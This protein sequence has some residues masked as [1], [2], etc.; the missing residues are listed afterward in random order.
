MWQAVACV[1]ME[2]ALDLA[3]PL[4]SVHDLGIVQRLQSHSNA[5]RLE[6]G[7]PREN[8]LKRQGV[9][10]SKQ[11]RGMF[12]TGNI[13]MSTEIS[14]SQG[15]PH[16]VESS[17]IRTATP[18]KKGTKVV[19]GDVDNTLAVNTTPLSKRS[20]RR[21]PRE[22][23][24]PEGIATGPAAT[25]ASTP[26][27]DSASSEDEGRRN[28]Y[29]KNDKGKFSARKAKL[30]RKK[31]GGA[32]MDALSPRALTPRTDNES[33]QR[34]KQADEIDEESSSKLEKEDHETG[35]RNVRPV[36]SETEM[37]C[38]GADSSTRHETGHGYEDQ[39]NA[40]SARRMSPN[41]SAKETPHK[42]W[43]REQPQQRLKKRKPKASDHARH[44][45]APTGGTRR[46]SSATSDTRSA[47]KETT[48]TSPSCSTP[49][50][51]SEVCY[52]TVPE[53]TRSRVQKVAAWVHTQTFSAPRVH[54]LT[55]RDA[56]VC[57]LQQNLQLT[58]HIMALSK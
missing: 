42:T 49:S 31:H 9:T 36:L 53:D 33:K 4:A 19:N 43:K 48:K 15:T 47:N 46:P 3:E 5:G 56:A 58:L 55:P 41:S 7:Q 1:V 22:R 25:L 21:T 45:N 30:L 18:R 17:P 20:V 24:T 29:L 38:K 8:D 51:A 27:K 40:E 34:D 39:N 23:R 28:A 12:Q 13:S 35:D 44:E 52:I 50:D 26:F 32:E 54:V 2:D 37:T 6:A 57:H 16:Q 11:S 10:E 14:F